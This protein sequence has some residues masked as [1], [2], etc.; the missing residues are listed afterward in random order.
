MTRLLERRPDTL[1]GGEAQRVAIGRALLSQPRLL[2]LDEPLASLDRPKQD[3]LLSFLRTVAKRFDLPMV[4]V[5]HRRREIL[6][7]ADALVHIQ[8]GRVVQAGPLETV[9]DSEPL[10]AFGTVTVGRVVR[11]LPTQHM[12]ELR[13]GQQSL[14]VPLMPHPIHTDVRVQIQ[15]QDVLVAT[16]RPQRISAQNVLEATVLSVQRTLDDTAFRVR[17]DAGFP[18][19][20]RLTSRAVQQLALKP[21]M[22]V[23][24]IT[25]T[26]AFPGERVA[27][28][29]QDRAH[30]NAEEP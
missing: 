22:Q 29:S 20:A 26:V 5:S 13:L 19:D 21:G 14:W 4:M 30:P 12:T 16:A 28:T 2:L 10:R 8:E 15:P 25:K 11:H 18:V 27:P 23:Y 7:L 24:A 17:L 6:A 3:E 1:S 9:L